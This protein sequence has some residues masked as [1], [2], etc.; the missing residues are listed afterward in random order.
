MGPDKN[1]NNGPAIFAKNLVQELEKTDTEITYISKSNFASQLFRTFNKY[2]SIIINSNNLLPMIFCAQIFLYKNTKRKMLFVLHG[3]MG[4][5]VTTPIKKMLLQL[6]QSFLLTHCSQIV[7]VSKMFKEDFLRNL[8]NDQ[9]IRK[10]SIVIPNGVDESVKNKPVTDRTK[11][12]D[13]DIIYLG[14][15]RLEKG[16]ALIQK[17]L[18]H[19]FECKNKKINLHLIGVAPTETQKA[20]NNIT[21]YFHQK[22]T[23]QEIINKFNNCDII[24]STSLYETY[25][26][27]ILE[28][29]SRGCKVVTYKKAGVLGLI[30]EDKTVFQYQEQTPS[31][32]DTALR[33]A[34]N[35][36]EP[37]DPLIKSS[38]PTWK[39]VSAS[40]K[41]ALA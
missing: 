5:E 33:K 1:Q 40:Y 38:I 17:F 22:L 30:A 24:I 31:S 29:Y 20:Q 23:H 15:E 12:S 10:K 39:D 7:F 9:P 41:K 27:A 25:G 8:I 18:H 6:L 34:I 21:V 32:L 37:P 16:Y 11:K 28:A 13:I 2:D 35:S 19:P 4:K 36:I 26:I 3:E 14:G